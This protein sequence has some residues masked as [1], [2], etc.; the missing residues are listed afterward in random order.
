MPAVVGSI[1]IIS[2]GSGSIVHIGDA[3][4]LAPQNSAKVIGGA[5]S[6]NTGDHLKIQNAV[7]ST[8]VYDNDLIDSSMEAANQ[9]EGVVQ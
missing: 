1:K 5:G 3:I 9:I 2:V 4:S 6:F 7:S 8:T